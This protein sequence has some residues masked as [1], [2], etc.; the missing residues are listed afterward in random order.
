M[1]DRRIHPSL[2]PG[3]LRRLVQEQA[4]CAALIGGLALGQGK[5]T[6]MTLAAGSAFLRDGRQMLL[7]LVL[8]TVPPWAC[9]AWQA[10]LPNSPA[11]RA[12]L[13]TGER[14]VMLDG[15]TPEPAH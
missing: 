5:A 8:G 6:A 7:T 12:G 1:T 13:A 14:I 3:A 10:V 2:P 11:A 9:R 4:F 15:R